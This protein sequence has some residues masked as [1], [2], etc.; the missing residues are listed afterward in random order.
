MKTISVNVI[1]TGIRS[2]VDRSLG[3][4]LSTPEL[5][6]E[7][8][9]EFMNLQGINCQ[10]LFQPLEEKADTIEVKGEVS[11]KTQAQ[12]IRAVLFLIWKQ[13]GEQ[14]RF[15]DFYKAKTEQIIEHLKS[16]LEAG[17]TT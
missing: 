11:T 1:I 13:E 17:G 9:A 4:T 5:T 14:G 3:L 8:R 15:E 12:R 16:K 7:E 6:T 2:K 10:A